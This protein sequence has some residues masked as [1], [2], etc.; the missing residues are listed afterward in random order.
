MV[1]RPLGEILAR[2]PLGEKYAGQNAGASFEIDNEMMDKW[3]E[4]TEDQRLQTYYD[5][6]GKLTEVAREFAQR[7]EEMLLPNGPQ[8]ILS[9]AEFRRKMDY[10]AENLHSTRLHLYNI[11]QEKY[12]E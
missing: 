11:W 1:I 3:P 12:G 5:W 8:V 6:L 4:L 9:V 2:I 10:L 7:S